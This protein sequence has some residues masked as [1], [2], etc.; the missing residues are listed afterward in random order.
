M[1]DT[2][3]SSDGTSGRGGD[4]FDLA[5]I[6]DALAEW[7]GL[8]AFLQDVT[9]RA[10]QAMEGADA[11]SITMRRNGRLVTAA[12]ESGGA[13]QLDLLQYDA[14]A[15]P[16]VCSMENGEENYVP[17]ML[18]ET[19]WAPYP[20]A[21]AAHGARSVLATPLALN[22]HS[23]GALNLYS[24]KPDAFATQLEMARRLSA[25]AAGAV[26]VAE[27]IEQEAE[28]VRDLRTAMLS[29]SVIDQAIGIVIASRRCTA[30][31]AMDILR[32]ASQARNIKLRDLCHDMVAGAGGSPPL[33]GSF[34]SRGQED[35]PPGRLAP[36]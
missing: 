2:V 14:E 31:E 27:R 6:Q 23:L 25:Q 13:L 9:Q 22:S 1:T 16:C 20:A 7:R 29:R 3:R 18:L 30:N 4:G 34:T 10:V 19:R 24:G 17:D 26:A 36:L 12:A 28:T 5:S 21:A 33:P 35:P 8:H 15:G 11:C 32:R